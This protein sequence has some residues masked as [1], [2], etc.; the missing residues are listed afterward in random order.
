[1]HSALRFAKVLGMELRA[2]L[3]SKPRGEPARLAAA[4]GTT[5]DHIYQLSGRHRLPGRD[6]AIA[7]ERETGG[8][9]TVHDWKPKEPASSAEGAAA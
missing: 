6:L 8:A 1:M 5:R 9:V 3:S 7:I 2:Y 4:V